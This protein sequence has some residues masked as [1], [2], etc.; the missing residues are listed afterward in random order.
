MSCGTFP[1]DVLLEV[2][3]KVGICGLF[4]LLTLPETNIAPENGP[5]EKQIPIGNYHF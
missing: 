4:R 5:L 2:R 1:L 3:K